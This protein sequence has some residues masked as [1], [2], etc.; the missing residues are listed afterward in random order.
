MGNIR[1]TMAGVRRYGVWYNKKSNDY[2]CT[3]K[4]GNDPQEAFFVVKTEILNLLDSGETDKY[5]AIQKNRLA[6]LFKYKLLAMYYPHKFL[7]IYSKDHLSYFCYKAGIPAVDG[8]DEL[9]MQR[10][11]LQWKETQAEARE[12]SLIKFSRYLYKQFDH[13]PKR[14]WASKT[15]PKLKELKD[16]LQDFDAKHPKKTLTEVERVQRSEKVAAYVKERAAGICELCGKLTPFYNKSGEPYLEC[17]HIVWIARDGADEINNAVA[18]CP[19]CH[20]KMHILDESSDV[21]I[22]K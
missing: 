2:E 10:K 20:R 13:P 5:V 18:L 19:N 15:R 1:G 16:D 12:M 6:P 11:L 17:H 3:K 22:L 9:V 8:D 7:T 14:V 21:E 4:Y